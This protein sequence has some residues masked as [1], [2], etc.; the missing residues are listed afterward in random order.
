MGQEA[1]AQGKGVEARHHRESVSHIGRL[2]REPALAPLCPR[3]VD[4]GDRS[5]VGIKVEPGFAQDRVEVSQGRSI[6]VMRARRAT[7]AV[8]L[9]LCV[10]TR[11]STCGVQWGTTPA[12]AACAPLPIVGWGAR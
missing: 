10:G 3:L 9:V 7:S 11:Y 4:Q 6:G 2:H 8:L 5:C 12:S 1:T